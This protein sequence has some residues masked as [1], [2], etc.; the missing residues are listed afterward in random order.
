MI[1]RHYSQTDGDEEEDPQN[2]VE[3]GLLDLLGQTV[4]VH[5][6]GHVVA[7]EALRR[8]PDERG[9]ACTRERV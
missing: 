8:Q 7:L 3:I 4:V 9:P 6:L 2:T 1:L 5:P